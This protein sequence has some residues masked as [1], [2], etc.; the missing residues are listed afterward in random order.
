MMMVHNNH[1]HNHNHNNGNSGNSSAAAASMI[2][3]KNNSNN[4][5]N[6]NS[7]DGGRRRRR[8]QHI[9][10]S[11]IRSIVSHSLVGM[12]CL[13]IGVI[14]GM[15]NQIM[16]GI[17]EASVVQVGVV[18]QVGVGVDV[19]VG[20]GV[21]AP[22]VQQQQQQQQQQRLR[23]EEEEEEIISIDDKTKSSAASA[24]SNK[25]NQN[26][27]QNQNQKRPKRPFPVSSN[28]MFVDYKT[29]SR[30]TFL[31]N[32][33]NNNKNNNMIGNDLGVPLD[34]TQPGAE[35][36]LI[37]YTSPESLPTSTSTEKDSD[38]D[39]N[40]SNDNA[41][42]NNMNAL[43]NCHTLKV[44]LQTPTSGQRDKKDNQQCIAI[45]PQWESYT[46]HKYM[47][48]ENSHNSSSHV[49][50]KHTYKY[51]PRSRESDGTV[52]GMYVLLYN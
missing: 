28:K 33:N 52:L 41:D 19:G 15:R 4:N 31:N 42:N 17:E 6:R 26:Q 20:V 24:S 47:R 44:I 38:N 40:D 22:I 3:M 5:N 21:T 48:L 50:L 14:I 43:E 35:D 25:Q 32:N 10:T 11:T 34:Y 45:I 1:N 12:V 8:R 29:I 49:D 2:K 13:Y 7:N 30:E 39:S 23:R 27:N 36:V 46:I 51:V 16:T 9:H 18:H 37:I